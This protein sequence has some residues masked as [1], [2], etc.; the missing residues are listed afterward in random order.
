MTRKR[1]QRQK[2]DSLGVRHANDKNE[3]LRHSLLSFLQNDR[4]ETKDKDEI[5]EES[6]ERLP[7]SPNI[8]FATTIRL[9]LHSVRHAKERSGC[10]ALSR[11]TGKS[12]MTK[13]KEK[14]KSKCEIAALA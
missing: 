9:S 14:Q 13:K 10:Y 5:P 1:V 2:Q 11:M 4:I 3:I 12:G 8:S 7:H 6:K